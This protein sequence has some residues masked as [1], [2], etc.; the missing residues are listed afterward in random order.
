MGCLVPAA[1][2][3]TAVSNPQ[4][5]PVQNPFIKLHRDLLPIILSFVDDAKTALTCKVFY[6][7]AQA[8]IQRNWSK[9]ELTLTPNFRTILTPHPPFAFRAPGTCADLQKLYDGVYQKCADFANAPLAVQAKKEIAGSLRA[10]NFQRLEGAARQSENDRNLVLIWPRIAQ[11]LNVQP[12]LSTAGQIKDWLRANAAL[13]ATIEGLDLSS[14]DLTMIPDEFASLA[15]PNLQKLYLFENKLAA[16]PAHFGANWNRLQKLGL[17]INKLSSLPEGFGANWNQL[18]GLMLNHNQLTS[19]PEGFGANWNQLEGLMLNHNQL[20]SLPEGFGVNWNQLDYLWLDSNQLTALPEGFG[21]N[22]PWYNQKRDRC[23]EGNPILNLPAPRPVAPQH[24]SQPLPT[25]FSHE[26]EKALVYASS[27]QIL[28]TLALAAIATYV[29]G[30]KITGAVGA[31][32]LS[33]R[34]MRGDLWAL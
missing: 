22:W 12:N 23:L 17:S 9:F 14:L 27:A 30:W 1:S 11:A 7:A 21:A 15:L 32:Y 18:E 31:V 28:S 6:Q 24:I 16:L 8:L 3:P 34:Y 5:A 19:L 13:L 10:E 4:A 33:H 26:P 2:A 20:T 25:P 29:I